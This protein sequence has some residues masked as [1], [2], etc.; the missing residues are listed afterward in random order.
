MLAF[1]GSY[2]PDFLADVRPLSKLISARLLFVPGRDDGEFVTSAGSSFP[3]L[4]VNYCAVR[5]QRDLRSELGTTLE[6]KERSQKSE[7]EAKFLH[8]VRV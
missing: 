3:R 5:Y 8:Y 7:I 4:S 1:Y 6:A 2:E